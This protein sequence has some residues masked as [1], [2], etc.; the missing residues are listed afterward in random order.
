MELVHFTGA[1]E[2]RLATCPVPSVVSRIQAARRRHHCL[3]DL[4]IVEGKLWLYLPSMS[5][6][7]TQPQAHKSTAEL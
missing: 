7:M 6:A 1:R 5:S 4:L 3:I 2:K